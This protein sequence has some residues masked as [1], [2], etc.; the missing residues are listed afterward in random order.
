MN[1]VATKTD[2]AR[3]NKQIDKKLERKLDADVFSEIFNDAMTA[4]D[5]RFNNVESRLDNLDIKFDR[6]ISSV[7]GLI[8]RFDKLEFEITAGDVQF[9]RL[10]RWAHLVAVR[11]D[12]PLENL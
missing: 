3:L 11:V 5:R 7:D 1:A 12:I 9:R 4:I 6:L 2:I 10:V 8:G